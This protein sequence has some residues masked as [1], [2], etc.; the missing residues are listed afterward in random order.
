[1][2]AVR[3]CA[4]CE[5]LGT[6]EATDIF[7]G[8]GGSSL[9]LE[10]VCCPACGRSLIRVVQAI[11]HWDLAVQAHNANFPHADH[12][13]HDVEV[14]PATRF[15]RT[16]L[17]WASPECFEA[18][19]LILTQWGLRPIEDVRIGDMV[20]THKNRWRPVTRTQSKPGAVGTLRGQGHPGLRATANH[21]I[22]GRKSKRRYDASVRNHRRAWEDP[23]WID[24]SCM[25]RAESYW[26]SPT[27]IPPTDTLPLFPARFHDDPERWWWIVGRYLGDGLLGNDQKHAAE[28]NIC[29][30]KHETAALADD[31]GPGWV[32]AH[33]RTADI[34]TRSDVELHEFVRRHFGTGAAFKQVPAWALA[35]LLPEHRAQL[36]AGYVSADGHIGPRRAELT[37]ISKRLA[38]GMRL[39]V[40]SLGLTPSVFRA[41]Q[42]AT[43]IE[44]RELNV[45]PLWR[46]TWENNGSAQEAFVGDDTFLW[47]PTREWS[48][49]GDETTVYNIEVEEDHSY[50]AD[51]I[52]VQNCTHHAYCRGPKALTEEALRSRA[53]FADIIRFTAHHRYDAVIVENVVE[54]RLW[55]DER[56]HREKC[57]C[58]GT[59]DTWFRSMTEL[60]YDGQVVYFNSQFALPTPQS[61]DR[62]YVVFWRCGMRRPDLGFRPVSWCSSCETVVH[63]VQTWKRA[64][65]GSLRTQDGL[66]EWG[67][68]G[69]QY[70][71]TCERC[72]QPVA[73]AVTGAWSMID[74]ALPSE[75]IGDRQKPLA[76]NTRKRIKVGLERIARMAPVTVQVGGNLYERPG[77]A[78]VWSVAD[79]LRTVVGTSSLGLVTPAGGQE[80]NARAIEQP[81]HTVLG[82]DRLAVTLRV[83][84]QDA[85]PR[86]ADEPS[87]T[88][89]AHDRQRAVL[90]PVGGQTGQART[91]R[92]LAEPV[93]AITTENHRA[94]VVQNME[95]NTGRAIGEPLPPVTT[96]GNHML[97]RAAHGDARAPRHLGE[98]TP[99][100]AG[101]GELGIVEFHQHG[102]ARPADVPV[103][104]LRA[105]GTHHGLLVYNGVPGFV[106]PLD[107]AAGTV[108]GRDKQSLLVPYNRTGVARSVAEPVGTLTTRDREALVIT[109]EDVDAC[110]FRMLQWPELLRAQVMHQ[111]PGGESYQL[112]AR[113]R[114]KRGKYVELSNELRVKMIGNAVSAP[115]A[116]MLGHAL[117]EALR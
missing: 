13:V 84:S 35:D 12:D 7:C 98:P 44:G 53:T 30:G 17:L 75:R 97:V 78:R 3:P 50:V 41:E 108:T 65:R 16:D 70:L 28:V 56:G 45:Q 43:S 23:E 18:G 101:H 34:F 104:T 47:A 105:Q 72:A 58:G 92:A 31:L 73:P 79:P 67:R 91:P 109:D 76:E 54:A 94:V 46:V 29:C 86:L 63:G 99:T 112:T 37:T 27:A 116:T 110:L 1:M 49:D 2:T 103:H 107:D 38:V 59:F 114:N 106:R 74:W 77:Y 25:R 93:G 113:R 15:R 69:Q 11:N 24:A 55:C 87:S 14:I 42:H 52:V 57:S 95:H 26:A 32:L 4:S 102:S 8:A 51:G 96:G 88:I 48:N 21:G 39:L 62:M 64:S 10:F 83:G 19:T 61:R 85:A 33:K 9:G 5:G 68:Y 60:G 117:M 80:A 90:V 81:C 20:L 89:T 100:V 66:H 36:L 40:Q 111:L 22:W 6:L 71:Y 115:V 82:N